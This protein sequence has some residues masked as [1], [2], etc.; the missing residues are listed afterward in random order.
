MPW[1]VNVCYSFVLI[2]LNLISFYSNVGVE[3]STESL[4]ISTYTS[5]SW[6]TKAAGERECR[7]SVESA[8]SFSD[9]GPREVILASIAI[10]FQNLRKS[11]YQRRQNVVQQR[12]SETT[13]ARSKQPGT[14]SRRL[15]YNIA[16]YCSTYCIFPIARL[17]DWTVRLSNR[18]RRITLGS[19]IW[20]QTGRGD[21]QLH[22]RRETLMPCYCQ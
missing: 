9:S 6:R 13:N 20:T 8:A 10:L 12:D 7:S 19:Y 22:I 16:V 18:V 17:A 1:N 11:N 5:G 3:F 2:H 4:L 21:V 14:V 15:H